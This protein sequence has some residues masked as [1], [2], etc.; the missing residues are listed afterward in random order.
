M[1]GSLTRL[2]PPSDNSNTVSR[3][4]DSVEEQHAYIKNAVDTVFPSNIRILQVRLLGQR[5][6]PHANVSLTSPEH[7][8][9]VPLMSP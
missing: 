5:L 7:P 9:N 6:R 8:S 3:Y 1:D 2:C 4:T